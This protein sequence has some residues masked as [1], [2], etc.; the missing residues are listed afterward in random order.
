MSGWMSGWMFLQ[1]IRGKLQDALAIQGDEQGAG[2]PEELGNQARRLRL[3]SVIRSCGAPTEE[4]KKSK[5]NVFNYGGIW[6]FSILYWQR[7]RVMELI[8][9]K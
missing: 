7:F 6:D 3:A 2:D 4:M 8:D 9:K 5:K 1:G